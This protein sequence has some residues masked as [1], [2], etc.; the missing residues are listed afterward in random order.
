MIQ[1]PLQENWV[2]I[3]LEFGTNNII[4]QCPCLMEAHPLPTLISLEEHNLST[5][6][7][8]EEIQFEEDQLV[9]VVLAPEIFVKAPCCVLVS[10]V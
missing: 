2:M 7:H 9:W 4:I 6:Q 10:E 3:T 1:R 8:D 5:N